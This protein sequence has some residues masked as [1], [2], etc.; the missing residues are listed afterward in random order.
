MYLLARV[1]PEGGGGAR[2]CRPKFVEIGSI[3]VSSY[4][5]LDNSG[6][7]NSF[8]ILLIRA[9]AKSRTASF[10]CQTST[11]SGQPAYLEPEGRCADLRRKI[12]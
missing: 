5:M 4:A 12:V 2:R 8:F 10:T 3:S 7:E 6:P 11:H 9:F 1:G